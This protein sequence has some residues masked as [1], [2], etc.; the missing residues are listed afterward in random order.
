MIIIYPELQNDASAD[1]EDPNYLAVNLLD[2]RPKKIW[3]AAAG[4]YEATLAVDILSGA[5]ALGLFY[6]NAISAVVTITKN[7]DGSTV[8]TQTHALSGARTYRQFLETFTAV[9]E[10]CTATIELTAEA[11]ATLEAGV[12]RAGTKVQLPAP[13][14][15]MGGGFVDYSI[16]T[17]LST[18]AQHV[19]RG[20]VAREFSISQVMK[21]ST[22][23]G[24]FAEVFGFYRQSPFA[25]LVWES[26]G[27]MAHAMFGHIVG[28]PRWG[29]DLDQ[30]NTVNYTM[31]EEV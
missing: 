9:N 1:S 7:S 21:R 18:G 16:I 27:A 6:T 10:S 8:D 3:R 31:L 17:R 24:D 29:H 14:K 11:G 23:F 19:R 15:Q 12:V 25:A 28:T 30:H 4:V 22:Q 20:D 13:L 5:E 2:A 26:D